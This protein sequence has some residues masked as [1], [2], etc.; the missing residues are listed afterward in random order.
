MEDEKIV[1]KDENG[2]EVEFDLIMNFE[3]EDDEYVILTATDDENEEA[4]A[5]KIIKDEDDNDILVTIDNDI[6]FS[7]VQEA[8]ETLCLEEN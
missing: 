1:L 4:I 7:A 5:L 8:Y 3:I 6:E 2:E